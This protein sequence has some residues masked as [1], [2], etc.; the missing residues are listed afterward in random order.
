[1]DMRARRKKTLAKSRDA[2]QTALLRGSRISVSEVLRT[3]AFSKKM[4]TKTTFTALCF[5]AVSGLLSADISSAAIPR[6][7][8][9]GSLV[10]Q[11]LEVRRHA[12]LNALSRALRSDKPEDLLAVLNDGHNKL[13]LNDVIQFRAEVANSWPNLRDLKKVPDLDVDVNVEFLTHWR[14]PVD[15]QEEV[16]VLFR[17]PK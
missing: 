9:N 14:I 11:L 13:V 17:G 6:D 10:Q 7:R 5:V 12:K 1:M 8:D 3:N 16:S 2:A 4:K 15:K